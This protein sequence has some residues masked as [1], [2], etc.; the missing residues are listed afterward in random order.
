MTKKAEES[1]ADTYERFE[2]THFQRAYSVPE[3]KGL[4]KKAGLTDIKVYKAMTKDAP[5]AKTERVYFVAREHG[6]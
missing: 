1:T 6:K 2:E 5:D 4:L 3:I